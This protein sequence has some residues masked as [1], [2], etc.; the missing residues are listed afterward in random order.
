M[1]RPSLKEERKVLILDAYER[2]IVKYGVDGAVLQRIADEAGLARPLLRHHVGNRDELLEEMLERYIARIDA[3]LDEMRAALPDEGR[4]GYLLEMLFDPEYRMSDHSSALYQALSVAANNNETLKQ[5]L[6]HWNKEFLG[7]ICD[8]LKGSYP[9]AKKAD[10][11]E[12]GL[13]ILSL[14]FIIDSQAL[15]GAPTKLAK[16]A[17]GTAQRLLQSLT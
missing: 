2:C 12:V 15:L 13:G 5:R 9:Q 11:D 8:E 14:Y 16:T 10:I 17:M 4:I 6:E 1:P 7:L 3:G